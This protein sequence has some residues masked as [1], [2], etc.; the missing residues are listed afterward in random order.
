MTEATYKR[1]CLIWV[2]VSGHDGRVKEELRA[3]GFIQDHEAESELTRKLR[4][5]DCSE[6]EASLYYIVNF[7]PA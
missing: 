7:R 3:H 2:M 6:F 1:K 4:Q 5:K